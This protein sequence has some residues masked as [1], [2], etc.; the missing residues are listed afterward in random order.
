[1]AKNY[2]LRYYPL[3]LALLLLIFVA[4][5]LSTNEQQQQQVV[6]NQP[7]IKSVGPGSEFNPQA[8]YRLTA[9]S[10]VT[11]IPAQQQRAMGQG[12]GFLVSDNLVATNAHVVI[13]QN[14]R[15]Y[16][17]FFL[18]W[19]SGYRSSAKPVLVDF[20]NDL[21]LLS[22]KPPAAVKPLLLA[23]NQRIF[24]GQPVAALG[25]P[26]GEPQSLSTGTVSAVGRSVRSLSRFSISG[27]IQTDTAINPGNSGGP[28]LDARAQVIGIN[29]QI[30]TSSGGSDGV[31]YAIPVKQLT[32]LIGFAQRQEEISSAYLGISTQEVWPQLA[33]KLN[34]P[35]KSLL[36]VNVSPDGPGAKVKLQPGDQRQYF[37]G[38][39]VASGGDVLIS[40]DGQRLDSTDKL[41]E[42]LAQLQPGDKV[43]LVIYRQGREKELQITLGQRP[44]YSAVP[45]N[46][47]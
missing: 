43:S 41:S 2:F 24:P 39:L 8:I 20:D 37:Q 3:I 5:L 40:L 30:Q 22:T 33:E 6:T 42:V 36:V 27:A 44:Q 17:Q 13:D 32:R 45:G 46:N 15:Q 38:S 7:I 19:K 18:Q 4:I 21:A 10:V 35:K 26:F 14:N 34:I 23:D 28:L 1:M 11:V 9:P 16:R 29:Q 47:G 25:S 12:S 31:S